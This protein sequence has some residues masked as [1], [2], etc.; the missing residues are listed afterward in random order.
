M[1]TLNWRLLILAVLVAIPPI[2][3]A[4]GLPKEVHD[5]ASAAAVALAGLLKSPL[6]SNT[7]DLK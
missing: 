4:I 7:D 3:E 1:K 5:A 6:A 2:L